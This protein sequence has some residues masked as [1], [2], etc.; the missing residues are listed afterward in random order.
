ML[1]KV[2]LI[3]AAIS[4]TLVAQDN[5]IAIGP[6]IQ[7]MGSNSAKI[8]WSTFIGNTTITD[9]D[10]KTI[11]NREYHH[12]SIQLGR[13]ESNTLYKYDVLNDGSEE[14]KGQF[15]TYPDEIEPFKFVVL[16]DT[17]C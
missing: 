8:C 5:K 14:G 7:Q 6:Y 2:F 1:K 16:G 9:P 4:T 12:H 3:I 11:D 13:L 10:G 17:I 15:R